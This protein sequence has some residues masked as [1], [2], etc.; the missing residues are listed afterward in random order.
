MCP[1]KHKANLLRVSGIIPARLN[2]RET[3]T[4]ASCFLY[5]L[6]SHTNLCSYTEYVHCY[7][8]LSGNAANHIVSRGT[9]DIPV[10]AAYCTS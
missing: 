1:I 5:L 3:P 4:S 7:Y 8:R 6:P 2:A 10:N 9:W